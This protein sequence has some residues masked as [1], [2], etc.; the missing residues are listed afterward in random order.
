MFGGGIKQICGI[1][2]WLRG[3]WKTTEAMRHL[4]DQRSHGWGSGHMSAMRRQVLLILDPGKMKNR[5]R[6]EPG[7]IGGNTIGKI[8]TSLKYI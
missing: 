1:N 8:P 2:N 3:A 4:G 7:K 5:Y 6:I